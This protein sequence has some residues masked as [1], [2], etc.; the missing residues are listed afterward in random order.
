MQRNHPNTSK[1]VKYHTKIVDECLKSKARNKARKY[2]RKSN[3]KLSDND[4]SKILHCEERHNQ[5]SPGLKKCIFWIII[6]IAASVVICIIFTSAIT[7]FPHHDV[8]R[9]PEYWYEHLISGNLNLSLTYSFSQ[10]IQCKLF[11]KNESMQSLKAFFIV[12]VSCLFV[13][14]LPSSVYYIIWVIILLYNPP[15]PLN[16]F[17]AYVGAAL[18]SFATWFQIPYNERG[19]ENVQKK[20]RV[21]VLYI[22]YAYFFFIPQ[23]DVFAIMFK[24]VRPEIQ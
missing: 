5:A 15:M 14:I 6:Y 9:F 1:I 7:I 19:K 11:F 3:T 20:F 24:T 13:S 10:M 4:L 23:Y 2:Q 21:Y 22:L 16:G 17:I 18:V 12:Y 8:L